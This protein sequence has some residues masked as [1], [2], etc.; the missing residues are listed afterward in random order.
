MVALAGVGL[1]LIVGG[2]VV[3]A[4]VDDQPEAVLERTPIPSTTTPS[5]TTMPP[6]A[7]VP[8]VEPD[9]LLLV[10]TTGGLPRGFGVGAAGLNPAGPTSVVRAGSI[11][12]TSST[13]AGGQAA[14]R[15]APGFVI[16]IDVVAVDPAAHREVHAGRGGA[17]LPLLGAG[18]AVL[19]QT[20][21]AIRGLGPG[22]SLTLGGGQV[23][24]VAVVADEL[25]GGAE[26]AVDLATG[27]GIGV[28]S[29]R[30]A[31]FRHNDARAALEDRVRAALPADRPVRFR[32]EGEASFLRHGDAVLPPAHIK[33]V[34]GEFS[35]R[36]TAGPEI[37][38]DPAW[39]AENMVRRTVP[40]LG[41]IY[42]HRALLPAIE[43]AMNELADRDIGFLVASYEGCVNP[44]L[45]GGPGGPPSRHAWGAAIDVNFGA[46]V[47][48]VR[49]QQDPRL[50]EVM[51]RWGFGN[52]DDWLVPDSGH[53]EYL[54]P[55]GL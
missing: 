24:V 42:C 45:L 44:H 17:G 20:G 16:P 52:G 55:P 39:V 8:P 54:G 37:V 51:E 18:E 26:A 40:V 25:I 12:L 23:R 32:A 9:P 48:G 38:L 6:T 28:T 11:G 30:Y 49:T 33:E 2:F 13:D 35:Y 53:F 3:L 1:G 4:A 36:P 29:E 47:T 31:L 46:N 27:A 50:V 14:D 7:V 43:G 5:T 34:F 21:A 10:W 22:A 41:E 15:P 19:S